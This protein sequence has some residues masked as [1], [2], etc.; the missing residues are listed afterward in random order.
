MMPSNFSLASSFLRASPARRWAL[1]HQIAQTAVE[2]LIPG[3]EAS[4]RATADGALITRSSATLSILE[5]TSP[6]AAITTHH[7][8]GYAPGPV[9]TWCSS[10]VITCLM[11]LTIPSHHPSRFAG[12]CAS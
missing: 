12:C 9:S 11:R 3:A 2:I 5:A 8:G 7:L 10:K 6:P 1:F 4:G